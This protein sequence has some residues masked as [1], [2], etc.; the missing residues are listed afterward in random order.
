MM[1]MR[2]P[3]TCWAVFKWQVINL[4]IS[5]IGLVDSVEST[6][7]HGP[8]NPKVGWICLLFAPKRLI[9]E[10]SVA[11]VSTYMLVAW[12]FDSTLLSIARLWGSQSSIDED[13][14]VLGCKTVSLG[15]LFAVLWRFIVVS[16]SGLFFLG[17]LPQRG[18]P[19]D[20]L[21]CQILHSQQHGIT[22]QRT[23]F[24]SSACVDVPGS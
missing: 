3:K 23:W 5:C 4:R 24:V 19:S 7:M 15:E 16:S 12:H 10:F 20:P 11:T 6:M 22:S 2:M 14:G 8:A 9:A 13:A 1:G 18:T 17:C 21:K